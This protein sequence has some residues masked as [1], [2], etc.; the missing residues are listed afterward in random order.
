MTTDEGEHKFDM[1]ER[2]GDHGDYYVFCREN[3]QRGC[4]GGAGREWVDGGSIPEEE[5]ERRG[6]RRVEG[7]SK[8]KGRVENLDRERE[9]E[10]M[11]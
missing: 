7:K 3:G 1:H 10:V 5:E 2:E 4:E 11:T 8:G 6:Y 9:R